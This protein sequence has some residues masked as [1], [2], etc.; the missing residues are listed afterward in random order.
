[1]CVNHITK[2]SN[3]LKDAITTENISLLSKVVNH[4]RHSSGLPEISIDKTSTSAL[5]R[6]YDD[7]LS[8]A[9]SGNEGES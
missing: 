8:G 9:E 7:M 6:T 5:R 2:F 3:A 4:Q 1:M